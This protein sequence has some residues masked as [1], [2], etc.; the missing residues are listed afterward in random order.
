[1]SQ[2]PNEILHFAQDDG[3]SL[4]NDFAVLLKWRGN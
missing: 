4:A 2:Y 1:M 3:S